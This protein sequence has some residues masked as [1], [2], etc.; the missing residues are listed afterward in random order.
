MEDKI[1]IYVLRVLCVF[2]YKEVLLSLSETYIKIK[3]IKLSLHYQPSPKHCHFFLQ[4]PKSGQQKSGTKKP[5][6]LL[7]R[8]KNCKTRLHST[9]AMYAENASFSCYNFTPGNSVCKFQNILFTQAIP[10]PGILI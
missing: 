10:H 2:F 4:I 9:C 5:V 8:R 7:T 1:N 3:T 6:I